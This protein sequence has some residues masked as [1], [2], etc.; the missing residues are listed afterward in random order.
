MPNVRRADRHPAAAAAALAAPTQLLLERF[1]VEPFGRRAPPT[2]VR[3][4]VTRGGFGSFAHAVRLLR[5]RLMHSAARCRETIRAF[6]CAGPSQA[7]SNNRHRSD[8][9]ERDRNHET[10]APCRAD[11]D[12]KR[13]GR[14]GIDGLGAARRLRSRQRSAVP[15]PDGQ[16]YCR[17]GLWRLRRRAISRSRPWSWRSRSWRPR[18]MA[19]ASAVRLAEHAM[20]RI[21][22]PERDDWRATAESAGFDFHT[23]DGERYWD[24]RAYYA[25]TLEEI[26]RRSRR[27]PARSTRCA[28][29]WSAARSTTNN[30]CAG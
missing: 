22:C 27:R 9:R 1:L 20:Q 2:P 17:A 8:R 26:E 10:L 18:R 12:G 7:M 3:S 11:V 29:N 28:S 5:R 23:I 4:R 14:R 13:G 21:A 6:A 15:G 30:I 19:A 25:F 24:E 16:P